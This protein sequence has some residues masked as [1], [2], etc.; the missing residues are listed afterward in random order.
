MGFENDAA[1][2]LQMQCTVKDTGSEKHRESGMIVR[3][4]VVLFYS[5]VFTVYIEFDMRLGYHNF[6]LFLHCL[7]DNSPSGCRLRGA[8][9]TDS[10]ELTSLA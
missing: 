7:F 6:G 4:L 10:S 3:H 9:S 2:E 5:I 8:F 1:V